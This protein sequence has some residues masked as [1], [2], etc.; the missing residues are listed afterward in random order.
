MRR[1]TWKEQALN[2]LA[3]ILDYIEQQNPVASRKLLEQMM[4]VADSLP[5]TL[6]LSLR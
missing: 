6:P 1:V 3:N 5:L 4:R 2:D